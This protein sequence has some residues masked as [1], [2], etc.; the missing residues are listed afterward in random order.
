MG[1]HVVTFNVNVFAIGDRS[2]HVW[3][4]VTVAD[5][6]DLDH[7]PVIRAHGIPSVEESGAIAMNGLP[8]GT[9]A[10]DF[11]IDALAAD[12][13]ADNRDDAP[14]SFPAFTEFDNVRQLDRQVTEVFENGHF[15][16]IFLPST[17]CE[18]RQNRFG[19]GMTI[20][21]AGGGIAGLSL[22]L[23]CHQIG[24]PFKVFEATRTLAPL[25]VGINLQPN[26]VRELFDLGLEN[27]LPKIG[28]A[29]REYGMFTK[30][31]LE[32]WTEPRGLLAGYNWPQYSVH[33]GK[34]QM[35]LYETLVEK[36]GPDC[37]EAGWRA[38]GFENTAGGPKLHLTSATDGAGRTVAGSLIV[39]ADGIHSAIRAQMQPDEGP[40]IWGGAV[41]WRAT[42]EAKPFRTGASMAL[43][44]HSTQRFV[45][46]PIS[47]PDAET[48]FA[49][50]N[51]IAEL[52]F[53]PDAGWN[54]EDWNRQAEI[55]AFLPAFADWRYDWLD[56]PELIKSAAKV[57]EYP[58]VD[59]DPVP[60]WTEGAVTLMGDAA[61]ATYPVGSN[62]ASQAIIDARKLGRH[63]LEQ[64][65]NPNALNAYQDE[66]LPTANKIVLTNRGSGPDAVLQM[67]EDRCGGMFKRI[68]DVAT[69]EELSA[70][71]AK[72]KAIAG[73]AIS[74]LNSSPPIIPPGAKAEV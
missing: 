62:G 23:T 9:N 52:T 34:L 22:A 20:L 27:A 29:T 45:T 43:I 46:Y 74:E 47:E 69:E 58:M 56:P 67:I 71:A 3:R 60:S 48:G 40:P 49:T 66:M 33:R 55:S 21:I 30:H 41:L 4:A 11:T 37:V 64:G 72:Y 50:I 68:E 19:C 24:I 16:T 44:G 65:V 38:A 14:R 42:S 39:G 5:I 57:F 32:I 53:D 59:R 25:G 31:G 1:P 36:S 28:V 2:N 63:L 17:A 10:Q 73:F 51:W 26:A 12:P 18:T 35:L 13:S 7:H 15:H 54:K 70:H 61:H 6:D 8:I